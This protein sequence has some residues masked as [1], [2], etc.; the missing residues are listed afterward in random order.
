MKKFFDRAISLIKIHRTIITSIAAII[1][2]AGLILCFVFANTN[3]NNSGTANPN[4]TTSPTPTSHTHF[5]VEEELEATCGH[6]GRTL[7]TC[8]CGHSYVEN[9][10][11]ALEHEYGG[12]VLTIEATGN[13]EGQRERHCLHCNHRISEAIPKLEQHE[14]TFKDEVTAA[15]CT[16]AGSTLRTCTTCGYKT[17]IQ[18]APALDHT[19][20]NWSNTGK[21]NT[22]GFVEVSR[23]CNTCG[24]TEI[25][26]LPQKPE[27]HKHSFKE[28][29]VEPTCTEGGHTLRKCDCGEVYKTNETPKRGHLYGDWTTTKMPTTTETGERQCVCSRCG[30]VN[31]ETVATLDESTANKYESYIDPRIEIRTNGSGAVLYS[32][33][34]VRVVDSR[35]WGDPPTIRINDAGGFDVT[36]YKQDGTKV[37][38]TLT[39]ADGYVNQLVIFKDGSCGTQLFGDYKD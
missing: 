28:T 37:S 16:K 27:A 12:W 3:K 36:Y 14:H 5:Y 25:D 30:N 29:V 10:T 38:Y 35:A 4:P 15:T 1:V 34:P 21:Q 2:V 39:P 22:A 31:K 17:T 13:N 7:Y 9:E 23:T 26:E 20:S 11:P 18:G 32:Y 6:G 8:D 24:E 33:Y 19:W